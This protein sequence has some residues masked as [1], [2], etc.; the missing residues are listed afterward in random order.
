MTTELTLDTGGGGGGILSLSR[1]S[2]HV[3]IV[4]A[5]FLQVIITF[6]YIQSVT[7]TFMHTASSTSWFYLLT[8]N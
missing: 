3:Q 5:Q 8:A 4:S 7:D 1:F 6:Q 2:Y